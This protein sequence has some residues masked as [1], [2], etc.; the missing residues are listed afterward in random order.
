[1]I[2]HLIKVHIGIREVL[3]VVCSAVADRH[4]QRGDLDSA[5]VGTLEWAID[6]VVV[7]P[8]AIDGFAGVVAVVEAG[9][10]GELD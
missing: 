7:G 1:M 9:S 2:I 4:L 3:I 8:F 5:A 6:E 10:F